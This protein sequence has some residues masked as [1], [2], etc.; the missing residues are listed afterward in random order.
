MKNGVVIVNTGRGKCVAEADLAEALKSGK[1]GAYATDVWY[2]RPAGPAD[3]PLL[4]APNVLMTPHIG[5]SSKEN[6]L[7]IGDEVVEH[8]GEVDE[9]RPGSG[10]EVRPPTPPLSRPVESDTMSQASDQL[11]RRSGGPAA[12]GARARPGASCSTSTGT[13]M[14]VMEISHRSKEY[15]AVHNEA[16]ALVQGAARPPGQLQDHPAPGRR[17]PAVRHAADEPALQGPQGRLHLHRLLG[18]EGLQGSA[19]SSPAT[20]P[21]ASRS[22]KDEKYARLPAA[23][24]RSRSTPTR[25]TSTS[26]PTTPSRGRS[27]TTFPE[28]GGVPLACDM[29]SDFLWR[30][31]DVKPFGLIYAG[32]QKNLGPSGVTVVIIREDLLAQC[33]DKELPSYL[34]YRIHVEKNS[35]LQHPADASASTSCATSSPTT[36]RS[37]AWRRSR[38]TTGRRASCCT[39]ASTST[40][41]STS[42]S[43]R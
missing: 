37:A 11:L 2:S 1:V 42:R 16:I 4:T 20:T 41:A 18:R 28:T 34:R 7:R 12:A 43:S 9:V 15:E 40:P 19:R 21:A 10:S 3:C 5:A 38:R 33:L 39:A 13:G 14:S 27:G 17:P 24:A 6:L 25:S 22:T 23:G 36:S 30:P 29:S 8:P 32:A 35:P 31:F 26:P